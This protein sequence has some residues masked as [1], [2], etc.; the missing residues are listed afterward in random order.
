MLVYICNIWSLLFDFMF[1]KYFR[2]TQNKEYVTFPPAKKKGKVQQELSQSWVSLNEQ[3]GAEKTE[4][5]LV[6]KEALKIED[7][8]KGKKPKI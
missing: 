5:G 6:T 4:A 2:L 1:F 3:Q 7:L 8:S